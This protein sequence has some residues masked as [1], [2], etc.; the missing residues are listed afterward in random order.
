MM[1][2]TSS[3]G[4]AAAQKAGGA[5]PPFDTS[6]FASQLFWL[7]LTFGLLYW[8]M[9]KIA[10]PRIGTILA[11]RAARIDADLDAAAKARSAAEE[12]AILYEKALADARADSQALAQKTRD[13]LAAKTEANRKSLEDD[14]A[15]KLTRAEATIAKRKAAAMENVRSIAS[16]ATTAI[17]EQV[18]GK[19]A[20]SAKIEAALDAA[21]AKPAS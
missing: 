17:V 20:S 14:L 5:F 1:A 19:A 18:T 16:D 15:K 9:A 13:Q 6:T 3:A 7:A 11:D 2:T 8:L 4:A 12:A 10:L 21:L